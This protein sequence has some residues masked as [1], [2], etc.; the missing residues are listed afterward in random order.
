MGK[1]CVVG[2]TEIVVDYGRQLFYAGDAVIH[3]LDWI[4]IDGASG[5]IMEGKV[6]TLAPPTDAGSMAELLTWADE[7][8][9]LQVRANADNGPDAARSRALGARGIGL[10][11]TEH[12][13]FQ[14]SALR[15]MRQMIL[16]RDDHSRA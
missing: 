14:P 8:A 6:P 13:F 7:L 5:D 9:R 10:C 15:A 4:T 16:A 1:P 2:C 3:R 11:R 12:M